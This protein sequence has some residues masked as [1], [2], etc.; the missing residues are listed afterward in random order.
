MVARAYTVAFEGVSARTVEV[1]CAVTPGL[2]AFAVVGLPD[3][4][5]SEARD[6]VRA[7]LSAMGIALPSKRITVNLSPADLPKEGS[8]FDL[9]I[10]LALLAALE[11][12][13][14]DA[15]ERTTALGELS[16]DGSLIGVL[17]A[18]PA[19]MAAAEEDRTLLCPRAS[20]AEAAWVGACQ[21]I[22]AASLMEVVRHYTGQAP[23]TPAEPGEV[24][25]EAGGRC[26]RDVKG[27][28]RAKR[29]LEIA[30]AGRHHMLMLGTPGSGK[31]MLAARIPGI[32]P[33]LTAGE[34]LETSMIHSLAGLLDEGGISRARPFREP[35]H[36]AS[37]AAIV[38]GGRS[39]K[40]GE[41]SLAHNGVLFMD[42]FPEFPR[43]V[44]ETLRQPIETGE[45]MVARANAHVR[46]P[47]RFMLVA[48]AN[49]CKCGYLTDPARA[50]TRAPVCGE[51]YMGRISG[52]LMD[53]FDLRVEVPPVA[54]TDLD[55]PASGETSQQVAARV[56]AA[57]AVQAARFCEVEGMHLNADAEGAVLDRIAT[58]D[59]AGRALLG[60]VADRF[61]LTARG[62]HRVLRVARTIA[63]LDGC[64]AV[65]SD[66]VAEAVSYRLVGVKDA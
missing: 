1:Q 64:D 48:A 44:L 24:T 56:A 49:P 35:H 42:E 45:V 34:A 5:V 6:R 10:A 8:H 2:P 57:R 14:P 52:P 3:K 28:E 30:A 39:A 59:A 21:V 29:A 23:I 20:G 38:G 62:Y 12:V 61:G 63:D 47:C 55:L 51:D 65:I 7:A 16:L 66:H 18:L 40:P 9:P 43:G 13:P 46:Y 17:G 58:P 41:I 19:A 4:A 26:L 27:Q 60:K 54:Y 53:R 11:I 25:G 36:T 32:L 37:M 31:S 33:P 15:V 50:C 22:A